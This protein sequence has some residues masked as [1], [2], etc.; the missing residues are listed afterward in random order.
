MAI[1]LQ[2][3][4]AQSRSAAAVAD[5]NVPKASEADMGGQTA[6]AMNNLSNN[7]AQA[8]NTIQRNA[9]DEKRRSDAEAAAALRVSNRVDTISRTR[10]ANKYSEQLNAESIRRGAGDM[11]DPEGSK[12][13]GAQA[14]ELAADALAEYKGGEVGR[15]LL[16]NQIDTMR[17]SNSIKFGNEVAAAG[18]ELVDTTLAVSLNAHVNTAVQTGD[19]ADAFANID[20][21]VVSLSPGMD[22]AKAV[23]H[24]RSAKGAVI[25]G[26]VENHLTAGSPEEAQALLSTEGIEGYL[27]PK[28]MQVLRNKIIVERNEK[29]KGIREG[30]QALNKAST[31]LKVPVSSFSQKQREII[32]GVWKNPDL[33]PQEKVA[34]TNAAYKEKTGR[35]MSDTMVEKTLGIF[36]KPEEDDEGTFTRA[37]ARRIT[38][39][40]GRKIM[41]NTAT[42]AEKDEFNTATA[43][44]ARPTT[45]VDPDGLRVTID[46]NLSQLTKD[47]MKKMGVG[48]GGGPVVVASDGSTGTVNAAQENMEETVP[49]KYSTMALLARGTGLASGLAN[50][51]SNIP[52]VGEIFPAQ[53][54]NAARAQL[55]RQSGQLVDLY[56]LSDRGISE[57]KELE[58]VLTI[59]PTSMTTQTAAIGRLIGLHKD[60]TQRVKDSNATLDKGNLP[61]ADR[62]KLRQFVFKANNFLDN[63]GLPP[64]YESYPAARRALDAGIAAPGSVFMIT[65]DNGENVLK[66]MPSN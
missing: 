63:M 34:Q 44:L 65:L 52:V 43:E 11:T 50:V 47:A 15:A 24:S 41:D 10:I 18:R 23:A 40:L 49:W 33:T 36:V 35:D 27:D 28:E 21:E 1:K 20:A 14:R 48:P 3:Y 39:D 58:R 16:I 54:V 25:K 56:R 5:G 2:S 66:K 64:R 26:L 42:P 4:D 9:E 8:G 29:N 30:E 55:E 53:A 22:N 57:I 38:N 6:A 62:N 45:Y 37:G 12:E 13:F 60:L 32:A 61:R 46:P 7:I 17:S 51:I 19:L 31:I 59:S